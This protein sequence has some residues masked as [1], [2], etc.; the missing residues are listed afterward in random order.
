MNSCIKCKW[1]HTTSKNQRLSNWIKGKKIQLQ[2][3][4]LKYKDTNG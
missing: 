2:E 4:Q 1:I 3:A